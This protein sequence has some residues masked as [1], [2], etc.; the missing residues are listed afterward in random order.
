MINVPIDF[1]KGNG[2]VPAIVQ[3]YQSGIVYMLGYMDKEAFNKTKDTGFVYFW[4]RSKNR[5][6]KKGEKSGNKLKVKNIFVDCDNDTLLVNVELDGKN[7]CHT[8]N[9]TC[10]YTTL[11][12]TYET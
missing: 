11:K 6:W 5:L 8:G 12:G 10:F 3:D 2:F 7:V 1:S 4:S 9:I